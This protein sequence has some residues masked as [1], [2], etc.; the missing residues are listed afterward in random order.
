MSCYPCDFGPADGFSQM[1]KVAGCVAIGSTALAISTLIA[2]QAFGAYTLYTLGGALISWTATVISAYMDAQVEPEIQ[3]VIV[4]T[5]AEPN[6][7]QI[8]IIQEGTL[9]A[10]CQPVRLLNWYL[11]INLIGDP[12]QRD[13][14]KYGYELLRSIDKEAERIGIKDYLG[15]RLSVSV[16]SKKELWFFMSMGMLPRLDVYTKDLLDLLEW[17]GSMIE[18]G[19]VT[20]KIHG[21][22]KLAVWNE[23]MQEDLVNLLYNQTN[24]DSTGLLTDNEQQMV[25]PVTGPKKQYN[26]VPDP[27]FEKF[28]RFLAF[29]E[30]RTRL[31]EILKNPPIDS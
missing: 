30:E 19:Q 23:M 12:S 21:G 8:Y 2:P 27:Q 26:Y 10:H 20:L 28:F 17:K 4:P 5:R 16:K 3:G 31:E 22:F 7:N 24:D 13:L 15:P 29:G 9:E 25:I 11:S 14:K 18:N 6:P 1:T